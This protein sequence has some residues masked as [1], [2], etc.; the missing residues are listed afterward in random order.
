MKKTHQ[1]FLIDFEKKGN[2]NLIICGTYEGCEIPL[3]V[4][5]KECNLTSKMVPHSLLKG[6]GCPY[7]A[8][9]AVNP[10]VNSFAAIHPE[11]LSFLINKEEAY[12]VTKG[13]KKKCEIECPICK[14]HYSMPYYTLH[15]NGFKC[16]F[17]NKMSYP[18]KFLRILL[19]NI[20]GITNLHFEDSYIINNNQKI[21]YDATFQYNNQHFAIEIN[22]GQHYKN[23][24]YNNYNVITQQNQDAIKKAYALEQN[25]IYIEIDGR[26]SNF[27]YIK[28]QTLASQL[29]QFIDLMKLN[30]DEM[31]LKLNN[32]SLLQD[33]CSDYEHN[34]LRITELAQKY[35]LNRHSITRYLQTGK[36]LGICPSYQGNTNRQGVRIEAYDS[37]HNFLGS[38][39]SIAICADELNKK[40]HLN[41][42]KNSISH[43]L[44]GAQKSHRNFYFKRGDFYE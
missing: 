19:Q 44:N 34:L 3:E 43:V 14:N 13:S 18:N 30:W 9:T 27:S 8:G 5:C 38:Y 21:R 40:F 4:K 2:K 16:S 32:S 25:M 17:C 41:F 36:E 15:K 10:D 24:S 1:Q 31:N 23:C 42:L 20:E 37:E 6:C 29:S 12:E 39:P 7:C 28:N 11:L 35:Q 33:I 22:G 26:F